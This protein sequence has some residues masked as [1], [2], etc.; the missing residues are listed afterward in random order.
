MHIV[1][2]VIT[3]LAGLIWAFVALQRAGI[4]LNA[5]NPFL[6]QRRAQWKKKYGEKPLYN[7][8]SPMEVAA[9]L[10]LG[11]AKCE[12]EVSAQQKKAILAIFENEFHLSH[13]EAADLLL[14]SAHLLRNEVY[15]VDHLDKIMAKSAA[16]FSA[17][18]STSLMQLL[19]KVARIESPV[20]EEQNKLM[21]ALGEYFARQRS[22]QGKWA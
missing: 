9:L 14:A 10:L 18:Q 16:D 19:E 13:D 22:A 5:L 15:L 12:G 20:N 3:A 11:I 17:S 8:G 6:W 1:I 2:G 21:Q 7:L 4:D